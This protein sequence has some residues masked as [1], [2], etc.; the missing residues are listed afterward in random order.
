MTENHHTKS[1]TCMLL[2]LHATPVFTRIWNF[3]GF[4]GLTVGTK[5]RR[6]N[7]GRRGYDYVIALFSCFE[8][9]KKKYG[10]Y[11]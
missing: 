10:K 8:K 2:L 4:S 5:R 1:N 6:E 11:K 7:L 9:T 3:F